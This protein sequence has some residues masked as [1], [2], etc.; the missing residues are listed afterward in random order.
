VA[1]AEGLSAWSPPV[2]SDPSS[3]S[4]SRYSCMEVEDEGSDG[5][6]SSSEVPFEAA[7]DVLRFACVRTR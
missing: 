7:L 4:G 5:D 6:S 2:L 1:G 3:S